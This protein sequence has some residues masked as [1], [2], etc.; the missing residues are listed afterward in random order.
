MTAPSPRT[1]AARFIARLITSRGTARAPAFAA[2]LLLAGAAQ[3]QPATYEIDP[4]HTYPSFEADHM[5]M[6]KWRGKFTK[7]K[8]TIVLD[9][10]AGTGSVRID[11]D[12][13]SIDFGLTQMNS[14]ARNETMFDTKHFPYVRYQGQLA[15]FVD[16]A[17]TQVVGE[18]T[19]HG[20]TRPLVLQ[21]TQF[22]CQ[23]H[24]LFKR[25]WCGADASAMF[26]RDDYGIDAGKAYGFQMDVALRIQ[27]EA[28]RAD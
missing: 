21:I 3:A 11:I 26:M 15:A 10:A 19:L 8:G 4:S 22:K 20:V 9:R 24:P 5:G 7:S 13:D 12:P 17:P 1:G 16:G 28:L 6:S 14:V 27:V 18:L 2:A 23:P 25:D